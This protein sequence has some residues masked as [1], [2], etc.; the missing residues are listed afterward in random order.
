MTESNSPAKSDPLLSLRLREK[1]L[2]LPGKSAANDQGTRE[3][4]PYPSSF[5]LRFCRGFQVKGSFLSKHFTN[6]FAVSGA[7]ILVVR[8]GL[9][10]NCNNVAMPIRVA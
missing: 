1:P 10:V 9:I 8:S 2:P 7:V 6:N 3:V 4:L 5:R